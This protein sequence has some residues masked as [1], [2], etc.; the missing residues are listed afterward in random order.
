[1]I[2]S[3]NI[4]EYLFIQS[5]YFVRQ[6]KTIFFFFFSLNGWNSRN[7]SNQTNSQLI[8]TIHGI[9]A[10]IKIRW[11]EKIIERSFFYVIFHLIYPGYSSIFLACQLLN[12]WLSALRSSLKK[13]I[14]C[15]SLW[16]HRSNEKIS[17]NQANFISSFLKS[18]IGCYKRNKLIKEI[19]FQTLL[20]LDVVLK[21]KTDIFGSL[22]LCIFQELLLCLIWNISFIK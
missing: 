10:T 6:N 17:I 14:F 15:S 3:K 13:D 16:F 7:H 4:S 20:V 5:K 9:E 12:T 18:W 1:M 22:I 11:Q 19:N 21:T 8:S 2:S